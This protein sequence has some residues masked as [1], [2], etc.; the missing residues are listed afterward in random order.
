[1]LSFDEIADRLNVPRSTV[2]FRWDRALD[3]LEEKLLKAS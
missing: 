2:H 1:L 3:K